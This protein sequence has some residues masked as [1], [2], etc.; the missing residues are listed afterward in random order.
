MLVT[1]A[2]LMAPFTPFIAEEIY[3]GLTGKESVH[4]EDYPVADEGLVDGKLNR[5]MNAVREIVTIGLQRRA[6]AK[7]KVRQPLGMVS[8]G[9]EYEELFNSLVNPDDYYAILEEELNV[10]KIGIN[11]LQKPGNSDAGENVILD[12]T[13]TPELKLEGE[14]REIIRA[15]QEGR[16]KAGFNVEDRIILGYTGKDAVFAN[17]ELSEL[18]AHE[19]LATAV[20][21]GM[22]AD[23]E[24]S[25]TVDIEGEPL[26]FFLKRS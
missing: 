22:L 3:R 2:K 6:E 7:V 25:G 13:V 24:Y 20:E 12:T 15:I 11:I 1:L 26:T 19:T 23:A 5:N 17:A 10:K 16:K 18:I 21:S 8:L 4:L 14:A 9:S